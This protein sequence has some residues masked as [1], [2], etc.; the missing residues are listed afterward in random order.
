[1]VIVLVRPREV[2]E[3]TTGKVL[4]VLSAQQRGEALLR[5]IGIRLDEA[6]RVR[7]VAGDVEQPGMGL[8]PEDRAYVQREVTHVIHCAASVAFDDPYEKCFH[9]NVGGTVN[10]LSF[11][12]ELQA[13]PA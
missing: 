6:S 9:A 3:R 8:P 10:A 12:E 11:S 1:E 2:K 5:Q 4:G 13:D 7:F